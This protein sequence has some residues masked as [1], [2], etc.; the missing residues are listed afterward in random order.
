[1]HI[2]AKTSY[3]IGKSQLHS[4]RPVDQ[5][6]Q[7]HRTR[8]QNLY[9]T[10]YRHPRHTFTMKTRSSHPTE[11]VCLSLSP[12]EAELQ[13]SAGGGD[14]ATEV[15]FHNIVRT[16]ST[17]HVQKNDLST[18]TD[19]TMMER[20]ESAARAD[21]TCGE[22]EAAGVG[23]EGKGKKRAR[24]DVDRKDGEDAGDEAND[25]VTKYLEWAGTHYIHRPG[26][27]DRLTFHIYFAVQIALEMHRED[28]KEISTRSLT[29]LVLLNSILCCGS[30]KEH[31][32]SKCKRFGI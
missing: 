10:N 31:C 29:F 7:L 24:E 28:K 5:R 26:S 4:D 19:A 25:R 17:K 14:A 8:R 22:K 3:S 21:S 11:H 20:E 30:D 23:G 2:K 27:V 9:D 6:S 1:M 13:G 32:T 18:M 16:F 12:T 15:S